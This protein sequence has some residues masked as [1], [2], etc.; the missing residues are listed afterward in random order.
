LIYV[1]PSTILLGAFD[2]ERSIFGD[3]VAAHEGIGARGLEADGGF[4]GFM[5]DVALLRVVEECEAREF[6]AVR[7]ERERR[8]GLVGFMIKMGYRTVRVMKIVRWCGEVEVVRM[9]RS[10]TTSK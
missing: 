2:S 5:E 6:A 4:G 10:Y 1:R 9:V 7:R 3:I 8:R